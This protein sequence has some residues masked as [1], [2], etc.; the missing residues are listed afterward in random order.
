[1]FLK[2]MSMLVSPI[3]MLLKA[4]AVSLKGG[5]GMQISVF[6]SWSQI[7]YSN[8]EYSQALFCTYKSLCVSKDFTIL[9]ILSFSLGNFSYSL[10]K[11]ESP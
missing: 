1:M 5:T 6:L 8:F 10:S 4:S 7:D 11:A 3:G 2:S 9:A